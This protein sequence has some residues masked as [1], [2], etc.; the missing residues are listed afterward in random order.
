ML[1]ETLFQDLR[2]GAR[3]LLKEKG[4]C[5]LGVTVLALGIAG[6]T[7]QFSVIDGV[8]LRGLPFP[9]P[10]QLMDVELRDP[11]KP[12]GTGIGGMSDPD[13][14]DLLAQQKSFQGLAAYLNGSTVNVT[15]DGNPQRYTGAYVTDQFFRLLGTRP[16]MGRDF[17]PADNRPGAPLVTI[18][19]H[20]IW[21]RDFNADPDVIGRS[22]HMNGRMATI[23][24][25]M[26]PGFAFPQNEQLWVP[27]FAEFPPRSRGDP[28][29]INPAVL[30][31][32]KPGVT[33]EQAEAEFTA[34]ARRL[35]LEH[36]KTNRDLGGA[37][38]QSLQDGFIGRQIR[39]LLYVMLGAVVVVL[40]IAC[41]N[42]MNMQFAR[43]TLRAKELAIRGALGATR[44]R[45]VRQ[46]LTE[47]LLLASLGAIVGVTIARW[48]V[49]Y[50]WHSLNSLTFPLPFWIHFDISNR[51]LAFT[52]GT[53]VL[54]ALTS[55]LVPA[56]LASRVRSADVL[57]EGGR[58][59]TSRLANRLTRLLVVG[60]IALTCA[61]LILS[62]LMISSVVNQGRLNYGFD[63]S[64]VLSARM[65]LFEGDYP[66]PASRVAF[67]DHLLRDL[68][69]SPD[70]AAAALTSRFRMTFN[71]SGPTTYEIE[72]A[73]YKTDRDRPVGSVEYVSD[74]Y[75]STL[76]LKLL[77]GRAFN[78]DD[79]DGREP[80]AIINTTFAEKHFGRASP[81]GRQVRVYNPTNPGPW[82]TIVGVVPDTLMQGPF[83]TQHD[84]SGFFVPLSANPPSF[85][86]VVLR[87]RGGNPNLLAGT[88]RR[89]LAGLDPNL[90]LYFVGTPKVM[91]QQILA[92]NRVVA[93]LFMAFGLVAIVLAAVGLYGVMAFAVSQRTAEYG[94]R[95][96]LGADS[97]R[98][99]R[100]VMRQGTIQLIVG[101]ALGLA[102]AVALAVLGGS[103]LANMLPHGN[104][105]NPG[106]Y[107][108][109]VLLLT[110]VSVIA[111]LVP[112]RRA[113]RA[114][115]MI[116]LR[117]E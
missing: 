69:A 6:V 24:G 15:V 3:V 28:Q 83:D 26:P 13:Y 16:V 18:I 100:M 60:Q 103:M 78:R 23:I 8:I 114:D 61:L 54:A 71:I 96:A 67:F 40:L 77:Q 82:R 47:S 117:A 52:I 65:G 33:P 35:A 7:T 76:G 85:V 44:V 49:A 53:T 102:G 17:R 91:Q 38:V 11:T 101:L 14:E 73:T 79:S 22:V 99:L 48:A 80:V 111:C 93:T 74:G 25:V 115:P 116:A 105:Y 12:P 62:G 29:A 81:L 56:L 95:M 32:L 30:G 84:G 21:Q 66:T 10:E 2:I 104:P 86:T 64:A 106:I 36:P 98:I 39:Q 42:V 109:V 94:I 1:F 113:T 89:V 31:R 34:L 19:G 97:S 87:P 70:V 88:L 9:H 55:G 92:Q 57:K 58:G 108:S 107:A 90:P 51:V 72:G 112:A 27:L 41:V 4:F 110:A 20:A 5:L 37:L 43:A 63:T 75:F 59:N 68:R 50:L 46:M 45:L